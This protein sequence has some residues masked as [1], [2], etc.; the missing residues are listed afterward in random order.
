MKRKNKTIGILGG[1]SPASTSK[2]YDYI[3]NKHIE[4][5]KDHSYPRI[6]ISSVSFQ[7]YINWQHQKNWGK[8]ENNLKQELKYL[9]LSGA[10]FA[11]I[12]TNTMHR[13]LPNIILPLPVLSIIEAVSKTA[14]ELKLKSIG[15]LGTKF[16]MNDDYYKRSFEKHNIKIIVP[17]QNDQDEI[18][19]IIYDE[20]IVNEIKNKSVDSFYGFANRLLDN[21]AEAVL[22]SCTE[23]EMIQ[24]KNNNKMRFLNSTKI[25]A[26]LA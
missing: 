14:K 20:L 7:K 24:N 19:R 8:I 6:V 16:T 9:S 23:L 25:H 26:E 2:Y 15:L 12:A 13:I 4:E 22:L 3:I 10:D 1:M 5:Y 18:H 17:R 11:I 21:G